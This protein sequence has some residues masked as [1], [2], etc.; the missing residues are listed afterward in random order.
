MI[1]IICVVI[2]LLLLFFQC[3]DQEMKK[4]SVSLIVVG[5]LFAIGYIAKRNS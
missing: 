2:T 1:E 5:I 4:F 3:D